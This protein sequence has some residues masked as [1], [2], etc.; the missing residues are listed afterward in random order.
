MTIKLV[1]LD[2]DGTLLDSKSE[3]RPATV[4]AVQRVRARGVEVVLATGRRF[5]STLPIAEALGL[6]GHAVVFNG[7]VIKDL[8]SKRSVL[9]KVLPA[10]L[11][12]E[13][14]E[15]IRPGAAPMIYL[16]SPC[17]ENDVDIVTEPHHDVHP[18]QQKY[19]DTNRAWS[20][21]VPDVGAERGV[22]LM[23]ATVGDRESLEALNQQLSERVADRAEVHFLHS[24]ASQSTFLEVLPGKTSKWRALEMIARDMGI[25]PDA[26]LAIGDDTNDVEMIEA[27]GVGVAMANAPSSVRRCADS[28]TE[29]NDADGVAR[30][31]ERFRPRGL[32]PVRSRGQ[33]RFDSRSRGAPSYPVRCGTPNRTPDRTPNR[34]GI[35]SPTSL[36]DS[37]GAGRSRGH[38]RTP[39]VPGGQALP[40]DG[41]GRRNRRGC[42]TRRAGAGPRGGF[43]AADAKPGEIGPRLPRKDGGGGSAPP[44]R[45]R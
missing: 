32:T 29:D 6:C 34:S 13:C 10:A 2:I 30:A 40:C 15:T 37:Q 31:L 36:R 9:S 3:L 22:A 25:E 27:A 38:R 8:T 24:P 17:D 4:R 28:V 41:C 44:T 42:T 45:C 19:L 16:D 1:A 26:V 14:L 18:T 11:L 33:T 35:R 39:R 43:F 21:T 23:V 7:G 20:R 12:N 5:R